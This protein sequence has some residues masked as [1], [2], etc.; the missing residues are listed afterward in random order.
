MRSHT[1]LRCRAGAAGARCPPPLLA[2]PSVRGGRLRR[3]TGRLAPVL[4]PA[5]VMAT[6]GC[7]EAELPTAP[8]SEPAVDVA[9]AHALAFRQMSAGTDHTCGVTTGNVAY[10]WGRNDAGQLGNGTRVQP[11]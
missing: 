6:L 7:R 8:A 9:L 1:V 3:L 2:P 10:C 11:D 4:A 5:L